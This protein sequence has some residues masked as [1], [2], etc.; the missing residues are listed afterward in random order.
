MTACALLPALAAGVM[1]ITACGS[2]SVPGQASMADLDRRIARHG[3]LVSAETTFAG[4]RG[5]YASYRV[6]LAT[7]AGLVATGR[8][9]SPRRGDE[10]T[11]DARRHPA[12]LLNDGR[13]LDSRA[14][15]Y[16]PPEF[17]DV[18]VLS[19]DYPEALPYAIDLGDVML[20]ATPLREAAE[21]VP[22]LF[23]LGGAYLAG[24]TDVDTARVAIAAT[25][26]AVPFAVAA[27][28]A[29]GRFR[30]VALIYGA[31][32]L[33]GVLA[34]NLTLRPR[35]LRPVV[36]WLATRPFRALEPERHVARIAP[37]PVVMINGIDDPQMPR[38]AVEALHAAAREPKALVWLRTGHLMP[39]DTA[40]I[41][42]L[43]DTALAL[44]PVLRAEGTP[45]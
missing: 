7:D 16:L 19:L 29:D 23:S 45:R 6:R 17:G 28:A 40:L 3:T 5:R 26:F 8:L 31:G 32:D 25:S 30:N 10:D 14:V 44:L 38:A 35:F 42:T 13:E 20:H 43:V 24:R 21:Q 11:T 2:K 36:A 34:A 41:R 27:A 18:V 37:R 15:D 12:V 4:M 33:D 1:V 9:L 39:T 22:A